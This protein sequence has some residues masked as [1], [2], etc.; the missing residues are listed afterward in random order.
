MVYFFQVFLNAFASYDFF[1]GYNT[2]RYIRI[3]NAMLCQINSTTFS[4]CENMLLMI[5]GQNGDELQLDEKIVPDL[6]KYISQSASTK[7]FNHFIQL[8][9][10]GKFRQFDYR[11]K[12]LQIYNSSMPPDYELQN[13]KAPVYL[14]NGAYDALVAI[15][16][17][18]HLK[19]SLPN[20]RKFRNIK[21][22]NHCDFIYG[23]NTRKTLF[24]DILKAIK[25]E[26]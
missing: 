2:M 26:K 11:Q 24:N 6:M 5:C 22:F 10:S 21:S 13:V 23:K 18:E 7:Q 19:E 14:Y 25:S 1:A 4:V 20:V 15:K 3:A 16:D 8:Y 17:V 9:R 12:N